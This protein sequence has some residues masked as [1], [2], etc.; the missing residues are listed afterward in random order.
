MPP[1]GKQSPR[2]QKEEAGLCE[3][4]PKCHFYFHLPL[5]E[6]WRSS[7]MNIHT[8]AAKSK[9][10]ENSYYVVVTET[11]SKCQVQGHFKIQKSHYILFNTLL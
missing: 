6:L 8:I 1:Y 9:S 2:L 3:F 4:K 10:T 5:P 7:T 11:V